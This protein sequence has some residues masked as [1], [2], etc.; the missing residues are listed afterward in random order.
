MAD[1]VV[2]VKDPT[3]ELGTLS[4]AELPKALQHGFTIPN[5]DEI[6]AHNNKIEFGGPVNAMKAFGEAA[7]GT[8]TFGL[9][10]ELENAT[11]LTT[12]EAQAGRAQ[13][14]G[15]ARTLGDVAGIAAPLGAE[16]LGAKIFNPVAKVAGIGADAGTLAAKL[17]PEGSTLANIVKNGAQGATEGLL[18]GA[19]Q[20][21]NEHA[22]GDPDVN[23]EK[24][25]HNMGYGAIFGSGIGAGLGGAESL[26]PKAVGVAR[27]S[28]GKVKD[29]LMGTKEDAGAL[30]N[31]FGKASSFVSGKPEESILNMWKNKADLLE[32]PEEREKLYSDFS[33][34]MNDHFQKLNSALKSANGEAR[35]EEIKSLLSDIPHEQA[36]QQSANVWK[37]IDDTLKEMGDHAPLYPSSVPY[38]LTGIRDEFLKK[39]GNF[40]NA[41]DLYDSLNW[42]KKQIDDRF[43]IWGKQIQPEWKD[44]VNAL[45]A[46]RSEIKANLENESIWG[47]AAARQSSFND[48]Q[49]KLFTV[50]NPK[51]DF[52]KAFL[53]KSV[54]RTGQVVAEVDPAKV[55]AFL[56]QAG[57][58]RSEM[59][60]KALDDFFESSKGL[61][62]E[63]E[64]TYKNLPEKNFDKASIE[65]LINKNQAVSAKAQA[66]AN[67]QKS[68]GMLQ[69]GGHNAYLGEAGAL[70]AG[71]HNPALGAA[72][73]GIS[74]LRNPGLAI[75]RL[76]KIEKIVQKTTD[77]ITKGAKGIFKAGVKSGETLS[78]YAGARLTQ[79]HH[80]DRE[81]KISRFNQ[82]ADYA[83][84][85]LNNSTE[86]IYNS[87]PK[88][89][90][91]LRSAATR[92]SEFL[93]S[94]LPP[95]PPG[96]LD[97]KMPISQSQ[98]AKFDRYY[99][100][101]EDPVAIL[102]NIKDASLSNEQLETLQVVY[103]KLYEEMKTAVYEEMIDQAKVVGIGTIPYA[104][105]MGLSKF[106]GEPVHSSLTPQAI[107]A[108]QAMLAPAPQQSPMGKPQMKTRAKGL[109]KM[110]RQGRIASDY[111]AMS[112][113]V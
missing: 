28:L 5:N 27:D 100:A 89:A 10:R 46:I 6:Q 14:H 50:I 65:G 48:A 30:G 75:Q 20:T 62:N 71:I 86:G 43:P 98:R 83:M 103:P 24:L 73:E 91:S 7:A 104:T 29:I 25:L 107:M 39:A 101:V 111:G 88:T 66:Q 59:K 33:S 67:L 72:I 80:D 61:I 47:E 108:N 57:T 8:A 81:E 1:Q 42:L 82:D 52:S 9:S 2:T 12:P 40:K 15:V 78:G 31:V 97:E 38:K 26:V 99:Q 106:L 34:S 69:G 90:T 45:R 58:L 23:G 84:N 35:P 54:S 21:V 36:V 51:N 113:K 110:D 94:K 32:N 85:V 60:A 53:R 93:Q 95:R 41:A 74:M 19:G 77:M 13:E 102:K 76:A 112:D 3:G 68:M 63:I 87:A 4:K 55:R 16:A 79:E 109:D 96:L 92:A 105:K 44:S 11:G 64:K 17:A 22:M 56:S 49:N 70:V 18:Y 37:S